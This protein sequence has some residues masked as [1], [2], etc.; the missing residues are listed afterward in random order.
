[1]K[2]ES[3][4]RKLPAHP[5]LEPL[6]DSSLRLLL[7]TADGS[8]ITPEQASRIS[9]RATTNASLPFLNWTPLTNDLVLTN[10]LLQMDRLSTSNSAQRFFRA[11]ETP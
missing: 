7:H 4:R 8:P 6:V 10:G 11:V 1:M 5:T 9:I 3:T 2:S